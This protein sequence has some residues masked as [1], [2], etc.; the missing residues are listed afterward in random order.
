MYVGRN[1]SSIGAKYADAVVLEEEVSYGLGCMLRFEVVEVVLYGGV[2]L[3]ELGD[4][5][6][7]CEYDGDGTDE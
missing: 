1:S 6:E 4:G 5:A 2:G 3:F 7:T